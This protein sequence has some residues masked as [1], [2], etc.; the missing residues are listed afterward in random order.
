MKRSLFF[1]CFAYILAS[2]GI[3]I[4][5]DGYRF[6]SDKEKSHVKTLSRSINEIENDGNVYKINISQMQDFLNSHDKVII[7]EYLSYC[8]SDHCILP[9]AIEEKCTD[10][11]ITTCIVLESYAN[12]F[13]IP[14]M[15]SPLLIV[16]KSNYQKKRYCT[17]FFNELTGTT[18]KTRGYGRYYYFKNG[19]YVKCIDDI[20]KEDFSLLY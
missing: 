9:S 7:Y 6:L 16:D 17:Q 8:S 5:D 4:N 14:K 1:C 12:A 13:A 11:G 15:Q 3:Y 20:M 10:Y 19:K 18:F 2:C